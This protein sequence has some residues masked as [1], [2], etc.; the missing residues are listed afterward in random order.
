[1]ID[2]TEKTRSNRNKFFTV[3]CSIISLY[4]TT[5]EFSKYVNFKVVITEPMTTCS[6]LKIFRYTREACFSRTVFDPPDPSSAPSQSSLSIPID[7]TRSK[8]SRAERCRWRAQWTLLHSILLYYILGD[9]FCFENLF[10]EIAA[11]SRLLR[12]L[13]VDGFYGGRINGRCA[14]VAIYNG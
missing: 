11:S 8:A 13:R 10:S 3:V 12:R 14:L 1:M 4:D 2:F 6:H 9:D 5:F 7:V